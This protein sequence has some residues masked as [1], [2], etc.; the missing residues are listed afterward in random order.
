[1]GVGGGG[2]LFKATLI[3]GKKWRWIPDIISKVKGTL[4]YLVKVDNKIRF[5]HV[6]HPIE[7]RA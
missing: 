3:A 7:T 4:T 6:D 1:M 5:C 2:V